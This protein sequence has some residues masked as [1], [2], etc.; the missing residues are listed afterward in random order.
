MIFLGGIFIPVSKIP[1]ILKPISML[2]PLTYSVDAVRYSILGFYDIFPPSISIVLIISLTL[3]FIYM[4]NYL[5][6]RSIP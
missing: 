6:K 5:I 2:I 3:F 1:S 4:I